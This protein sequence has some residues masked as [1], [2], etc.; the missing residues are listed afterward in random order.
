VVRNTLFTAKEAFVGFVIGT[1]VGFTLGA[2][3][4]RFQMLQRG[5]MP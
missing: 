2:V 3:I 4:A 1:I 5:L